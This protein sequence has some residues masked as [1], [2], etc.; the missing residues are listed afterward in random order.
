MIYDEFITGISK[1]WEMFETG[2]K[3]QANKFLL[4][5]TEEFKQNVPQDEADTLLY[6]FCC[7]YIDGDRFDEHKRFGLSLPFQLTGLLNDYFTRECRAEKMPQMRWAF[8]IFG[9]YYNPHDPNQT[10]LDPYNI[11][12]RA[13]RHPDCDQKTVHLYLKQQLDWLVFGAHHFPEGCCIA[14]EEY[15]DTIRTAERIIAENDVP[16]NLAEETRYYKALYE[17]YYKWSD[18][19]RVGD[20]EELCASERLEFHEVKAFYYK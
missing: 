18:G 16:T 10:N 8:Q 14:R 7:D 2:L 20:F 13:Y 6:E 11:L 4:G 9:N 17:L 1:Y 5:F 3:K 15:D 19:G 12:E